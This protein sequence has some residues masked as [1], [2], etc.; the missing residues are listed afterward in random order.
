MDKIQP[1]LDINPEEY[2][3][4][5][6]ETWDFICR[7]FKENYSDDP[8][9]AE[10]VALLRDFPYL[11]KSDIRAVRRIFQEHIHSFHDIINVEI[12]NGT[13]SVV[14]PEEDIETNKTGYINIVRTTMDLLDEFEKTWS[15]EDDDALAQIA[16][17]TLFGRFVGF[18]TGVFSYLANAGWEPTEEEKQLMF[19]R[20]EAQ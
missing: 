20:G 17:N 3:R 14:P 13:I 2:T 11:D 5:I 4:S 6:Y 10:T 9:P 19:D 16:G 15:I 7:S 18:N 12:D 1:D 8:S